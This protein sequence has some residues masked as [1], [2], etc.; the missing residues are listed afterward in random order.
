MVSLP[1]VPQRRQKMVG[2]Q[3]LVE[4]RLTVVGGRLWR[5]GIAR[6]HTEFARRVHVV[7]REIQ[8]QA[9]PDQ[10]STQEYIAA[11]ALTRSRLSDII[12]PIYA[13]GQCQRREP[14]V[15]GGTRRVVNPDRAARRGGA[16]L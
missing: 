15:I 16:L 13:R 10:V 8:T 1:S 7:E 9:V 12:R 6:G 14:V 5:R 3:G 11:P 4:P 2:M